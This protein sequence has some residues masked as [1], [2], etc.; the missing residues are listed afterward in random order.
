MFPK[1]TQGEKYPDLYEEVASKQYSIESVFG[2][3]APKSR[4]AFQKA[5]ARTS[6]NKPDFVT[7]VKRKRQ[8]IRPGEEPTLREEGQTISAA[9]L[10]KPKF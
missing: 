3:P 6:S 10:L 7:E 1:S 5:K 8:F 4:I 9:N 2:T